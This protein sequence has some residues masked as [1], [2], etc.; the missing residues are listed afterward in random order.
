[1]AIYYESR[2]DRL[3]TAHLTIEFGN[4]VTHGDVGQLDQNMRHR[5]ADSGHS[6]S[7]SCNFIQAQLQ[8]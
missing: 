8:W 2:F 7:F 1:V 4:E 5:L 3:P 6:R